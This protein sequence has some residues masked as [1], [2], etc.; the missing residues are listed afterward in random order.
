MKNL[1]QKTRGLIR[2]TSSAVLLSVAIHVVLLVLA[3]S[4]VVFTIVQKQEQKF[5][6]PPPVDRPKMNL[7]KPNVKMKNSSKSGGSA[8]RI[9][10]KAPAG[11]S[12]MQLPSLE[13]IG[14]GL[15]GGGIGGFQLM[16]TLSEMS[17]LGASKSAAIGN[18]FEGTFYSLSYNRR[19]ER[20]PQ[21]E[22]MFCAPILKEFLEC[23]WNPRVF[24]P[25]YRS[26]KKIYTSHFIIPPD[27]SATG[28]AAFGI[29][30]PE[31]NPA[32]WVVHYKGKIASRKDGRFR[33]WGTG[34]FLMIVRVDKKIVLDAHYYLMDGYVI[35]WKSDSK[36][37]KKYQMA[38]QRARVGNWFELKA[39][40]P[41]EMEVLLYED[42]GYLGFL[43]AIQ[44][45]GVEYPKN[46]EGMPVLPAFKTAEFPEAIKAQ[47]EYH[48]NRN[49]VNL[50]SDLMFNVY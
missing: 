50:D 35:P 12:D 40:T 10:S 28:P 13:G 25:Y 26:P 15:G 41:V 16:P 30:D 5:V 49:E 43:L 34:D 20:L 36:E 11:I 37:N 31:F 8:R 21:L 38:F 17:L 39:E 46:W 48:L 45:E 6:P 42:G 18:D 32:N 19:L 22:Y 14:E 23:G 9:V 3:G 29:N 47:M 33:F 24:T 44:E 4:W 2:G 7:I 1:I 27:A